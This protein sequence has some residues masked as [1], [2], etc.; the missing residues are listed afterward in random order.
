MMFMEERIS[1]IPRGGARRPSSP[2]LSSTSIAASLLAAVL[3]LSVAACG[4]RRLNVMQ[5]TQN[6]LVTVGYSSDRSN[7]IFIADNEAQ[8]YC[9][10]QNKTVVFLNQDTVYQ[11]RYNEDVTAAART[12]GRVADALGSS[13]A[14]RAS[15][16][17][18]SST[19][20]K[21]TFEFLC[22]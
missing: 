18:S 7:S 10:R 2:R 19:D 21:T 22:K 16:A 17:L 5:T 13:K 15:G 3:G 8:E 12:A 20:Y 6:T 9:Q 14:A 1:N 11:G 4:P